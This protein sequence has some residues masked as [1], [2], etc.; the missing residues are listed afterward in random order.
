MGLYDDLNRNPT[1]RDL[2]SFGVIVAAGMATI[3]G[4]LHHYGHEERALVCLAVGGAVLVLSWVPPIGRRLYVLWMGLGMTIGFF[5]A[6]VVML[7]V[8]FVV[9]VPV[10]LWFKLV[11]RDAMRR[12]L[13]PQATSYWED[14]P[15]SKEPA[16]YVRQF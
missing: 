10:G 3:A 16:S 8:Y 4:L 12:R 9:V 11:R 5:T 7:V 13:D 15:R 2:V 1:R 6:P 14:Y